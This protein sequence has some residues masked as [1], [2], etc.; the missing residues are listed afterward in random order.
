[1]ISLIKFII[2]ECNEIVRIKN[3]KDKK[4]KIKVD[5]YRIENIQNEYINFLF[6]ISQCIEEPVNIDEFNLE[7]LEK[8]IRHKIRELLKG[9]VNISINLDQEENED[10]DDSSRELVKEVYNEN[11]E[12]DEEKEKEKNLEKEKNKGNKKL[13]EDILNNFYYFINIVPKN[14][15]RFDEN[16]K[17]QFENKFKLKINPNNF[18]V[19]NNNKYFID[20]LVRN[21]NFLNLSLN[22]IK[23][24]YPN[25]EE[26]YE[27]K[28]IFEYLINECDIKNYIDCKGNFIIKINDKGKTNEVYYPPYGWIGIG[29]KIKNNDDYLNLNYN[30]NEWAIA[31]YGVGGRLSINEVK[32]KLKTK[33]KN[34]LNQGKSQTK[35]NLNDIR[36]HGKKIGTGVYLTPNINLVE[37]YCGIITFNKEKYRVA[38]MVKVKIDKIRE[39]KDINFWILN[40]K[41]IRPYRILLKKINKCRLS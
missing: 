14:N 25:L 1:M 22:E 36:H 32:D 23:N 30:D 20:N 40:S 18:I 5:Y 37:N 39:P 29:L 12:H 41:Y 13:Y 4:I 6:D 17:K 33:I 38:L 11:S 27:Y 35:W 7:N 10:S 9:M 16:A 8:D 24:L 3:D 34:G 21:N 31:Y 15:S 2:L 28:S 19:S 26:L